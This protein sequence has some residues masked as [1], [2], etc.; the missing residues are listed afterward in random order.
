MSCLVLNF[1]APV[2]SSEIMG[3]ATNF[4]FGMQINH[5]EFY[6][7][8]VRVTAKWHVQSDVTLFSL[9]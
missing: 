8:H 1:R 3:E 6:S 9:K 2:L 4:R 5:N 7:R